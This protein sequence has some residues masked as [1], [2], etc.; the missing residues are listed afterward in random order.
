MMRNSIFLLLAALLTACSSTAAQQSRQPSASDVVATVGST[1]I[2]LAQ[3]DDKA[4]Q[5]PASN[6]GS[7]K[8]VQALYEARRAAVEEVVAT[9]LFE[10]EAKAQGIDR[11]IGAIRSF[12]RS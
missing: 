12:F 6:F 11:A 7:A 9:T 5:Q 2:T 3:V 1:S 4:L 10:Q 8:L